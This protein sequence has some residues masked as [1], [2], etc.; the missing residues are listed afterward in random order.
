MN[1][2]SVLLPRDQ[3]AHRPA[4]VGQI[5][6]HNGDT[7]DTAEITVTLVDPSSG[8]QI[9][10]TVV[11]PAGNYELSATS[12]GTYTVV[13]MARGRQPAV[14][15]V[16]LTDRLLRHDVVLDET[17]QLM[18]TIRSAGSHAGITGALV[19]L[20]DADGGITAR[21][22]TSGS[23]RYQLFGLGRGTYAMTVAAAH[24]SPHVATVTL[25]GATHR[26]GQTTR[27]IELSP[28][29]QINGTVRSPGTDEPLEGARVILLHDDGNVAATVVTNADGTYTSG[30]L[31]DGDYTVVATHQFIGA[32]SV[33][34]S[35]HPITLD[36]A[37]HPAIGSST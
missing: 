16:T 20:T 19:L 14:S 9:D 3:Q 26:D 15:A 25:P 6:Q 32:T 12:A 18:G 36:V 23:G 30:G 1:E 13:C 2:A 31:P 11:D 4:V 28:P 22:I 5:S 7:T 35:N 27:D 10:A 8:R 29:G 21:T 34:V 17:H 33:T 37:L 24:F